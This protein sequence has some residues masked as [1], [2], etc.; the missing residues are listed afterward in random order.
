M[1]LNKLCRNCIFWERGKARYV[2][3][4]DLPLFEEFIISK[5]QEGAGK[6]YLVE[7]ND[8][9]PMGICDNENFVYTQ[10]GGCEQDDLRAALKNKEALLYSD[11][12]AYGAYFKTCEG[13]GCIHFKEKE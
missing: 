13:F 12:E 3:E 7:M 2:W 5:K 4:G 9:Y 6:G 1:E 8:K 11:G 10:A